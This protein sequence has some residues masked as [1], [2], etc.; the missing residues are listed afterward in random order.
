[1]TKRKS[2]GRNNYSNDDLARIVDQRINE[3]LVELGLIEELNMG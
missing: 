2:I 3:K 1:M